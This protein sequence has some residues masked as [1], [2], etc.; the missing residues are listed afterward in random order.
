MSRLLCPILAM[1]ALGCGSSS[2]PPPIPVVPVSGKVTYKGAPVKEADVSF[3]HSEENKSAFGR[4]NDQ[5][6]Y[7]LTTFSANDGA[8]VGHHVVT[9]SKS[10]AAAA[11]TPPAPPESPDYVPPK[12]N[13]STDPPRPKSTLPEKFAKQDSSGLTAD[14]KADG[15]NDAINFDLKD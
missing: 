15:A 8:I 11:V 2:P 12:F 9:V 13:Q 4:T 6:E 7:K 14:V 3:F 5:G 10:E 1:F